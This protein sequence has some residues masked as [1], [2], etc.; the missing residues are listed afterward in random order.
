MPTCRPG[1]EPGPQAQGLGWSPVLGLRLPLLAMLRIEGQ[2]QPELG[3]DM[4]SGLP[5]PDRLR[6]GR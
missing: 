3:A 6:L 5:C 1:R 4:A 2:T